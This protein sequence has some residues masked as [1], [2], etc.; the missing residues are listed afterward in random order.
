MNIN[1]DSLG[2]EVPD[3]NQISIVVPDLT[4]GIERYSRIFGIDA[5]RVFRLD[6]DIHKTPD[7]APHNFTIKAALSAD[8]M[9]DGLK[10]WRGSGT[11]IELVE[12]TAGSS[13]MSRFL[14]G[15][16]EGIHHV[17]CWDLD[18]EKTRRRFKDAGYDIRQTS[19]VFGISEYCYVDTREELSGMMLEI[20]RDAEEEKPTPAE[21]DHVTDVF[22][23]TRN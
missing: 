19:H 4:D 21:S 7:G 16:G 15:N 10:L 13:L 18:Y 5:W 11:E 2:V 8:P 1:I 14:E 20:A 12:P 9:D 6:G 3:I 22:V 17:A 23:T